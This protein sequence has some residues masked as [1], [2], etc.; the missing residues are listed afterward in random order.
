MA[1]FGW[2]AGIH[3]S[4]HISDKDSAAFSCLLGMPWVS[5]TGHYDPDPASVPEI[6]AQDC[7]TGFGEWL[8]P[9]ISHAIEWQLMTPDEL[10]VWH[11]IGKPRAIVPKLDATST[12]LLR[13]RARDRL[14]RH[15]QGHASAMGFVQGGPSGNAY[16]YPI[17][18]PG[19]SQLPAPLSDSL[20]GTT[21]VQV[22]P[23]SDIAGKL[24]AAVP[25]FHVDGAVLAPTGKVTLLAGPTNAPP[26]VEF[27][28]DG[29]TKSVG[30]LDYKFSG[31]VVECIKSDEHEKEAEPIAPAPVLLLSRAPDRQLYA[32]VSRRFWPLKLWL[33]STRVAK[34]E[35]TG[36]C[37]TLVRLLGCGEDERADN[38]A[39]GSVYEF[40]L[41]HAS[42]AAVFPIKVQWDR[43]VNAAKIA[44]A[45]EARLK[46]LTFPALVLTAF[47]EGLRQLGL[48]AEEEAARLLAKRSTASDAAITQQDLAAARLLQEGMVKPGRGA[49]PLWAAWLA[50][51]LPPV[52]QAGDAVVV[53][54]ALLSATKSAM[55]IP[56]KILDPVLDDD[57]LRVMNGQI[58][59]CE[60]FW[61]AIHAKEDLAAELDAQETIYLS[62][63][64]KRMDNQALIDLK[65]AFRD[66][67]QAIAAL[68]DPFM[69]QAEDA[70]LRLRYSPAVA[71]ESAIRGCILALR[72]GAPQ[73]DGSVAWRK[74]EWITTFNAK[75]AIDTGF[76][77]PMTDDEG[78]ALFLDTQGATRSDGLM[79]QVTAYAGTP[80]FT[81]PPAP[82]RDNEETLPELFERVSTARKVPPLAYSA[83][84]RAV[85]G[86][87]DNAGVILERDLW[88]EAP[89]DVEALPGLP[90]NAR[91]I[92]DVH[93]GNG[94]F[95]YL[96]KQPP[97]LPTF[98]PIEDH[99][100]AQDTL[101]FQA[102]QDDSSDFRV[103]V[104]YD[105]KGYVDS[106]PEQTLK[107]YAPTASPGFVQRWLSADLLVPDA[108]R[109]SAVK[110]WTLEEIERLRDSGS[111]VL[112]DKAGTNA[113][114]H[115]AV[116][117]VELHVRWHSS[118]HQAVETAETLVWTLHHLSGKDWQRKLLTQITLRRV[119]NTG[120]AS[121]SFTSVA[122]G[123]FLLTV[124][125]GTHAV[126]E[127]TTIVLGT[128]L[129]GAF[130]RF[131]REALVNADKRDRP[132]TEHDKDYKSL[133]A[134]RIHVE[135]LPDAPSST[136]APDTFKLNANEFVIAKPGTVALQQE[137]SLRLTNAR[138]DAQWIRGARLE[139]K[140]WQWSGYPVTFPRKDDLQSWLSLYS[141][142]ID[143]MP[144]VDNA[145][146]TTVVDAHGNWV[147]GALVMEPLKLA[148]PRPASH[149]GMVVTPIPR[150]EALLTAELKAT[151]KPSFVY[152]H[153]HGV[154]ARKRLTPPVWQEAIPLPHTSI[155][156]K[157]AKRQVNPGNLIVLSDPLY[158][159]SDTGA[160]GGIAERV[161]LDVVSTWMEG[162]EEIGPNPIF[163][164]SPWTSA[165]HG[166]A[167]KAEMEHQASLRLEAPFGLGYDRVVGG[168]PAQTGAVVRPVGAHGRWLLAKCR[169]R[170]LVI[171]DLILDSELGGQRGWLEPRRV[172][173][174]W[175]PEDFAVYTDKPLSTMK[176]GKYEVKLP[177][178]V[179]APGADE[180]LV[181]LVTWHRDRWGEAEITWRPLVHVYLRDAKQDAWAL[182]QHPAPYGQ[183][184]Y[185]L[186]QGGGAEVAYEL[187]HP[188]VVYHVDASDYTDSRWLSF[189]GSFEQEEV[190]P[191][192]RFNLK[193]TGDAFEL[194]SSA[195][196]NFE[197]AD[198]LCPTLLL[199]FNP[200]RDL[201][202]GRIAQDGG[203][204]VGVYA[205]TTIGSGPVKFDKGILKAEP[206]AAEPGLH[207]RAVVM[208]LQRRN[209][210]GA[211]EPLPSTW[212]DMVNAMFPREE[213]PADQPSNEARMRLVPEYIGP[214]NVT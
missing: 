58:D 150:F 84:Y 117:A 114:P 118:N 29:P 154:S 145:R 128:H 199:I 197:P 63:I 82:A 69:P 86:T 89:K 56:D 55:A 203:E 53:A 104:L 137:L 141:G 60:G 157:G 176:V 210:P 170:R 195:M 148:A 106:K 196:P 75:P 14:N 144:A 152:T 9:W 72:A 2:I 178:G 90:R 57:V 76:G 47:A 88:K 12:K 205:A 136:T 50:A 140:R 177:A 115:P 162:L 189:I 52:A 36:F 4:S 129:D 102:H 171:P 214:I 142:T 192:D 95:Q 78:V 133:R 168:R 6:P 35:A 166:A 87:V 62:T 112:Q 21:S 130:A 182:Q 92:G 25:V 121:R 173:D 161:E 107:L 83:Y 181:Y 70:P 138:R 123:G 45:F 119:A 158:D 22:A 54:G 100:V 74:G 64:A 120:P 127:A 48:G 188:A 186:E 20:L 194:S 185:P 49:H 31:C 37:R 201:M 80:L 180:C 110:G 44:A 42:Y 68:L 23:R 200:Q 8:A 32:E 160:F 151:I 24:V 208:K 143:A 41:D 174:G 108:H 13:A 19:L 51:V 211:K 111:T 27:E 66:G 67:V 126:L 98:G 81:A 38:V 139:A 172:E 159:T 167:G 17:M 59:Y 91:E 71:A 73:A 155:L 101:S 146:F 206:L 190:T 147:L 10:G 124:P 187:S 113:I 156:E 132:Y 15:V 164:K 209:S 30:G 163:H 61:G 169:M 109:W 33:D 79:E 77:A 134:V 1:A 28:Y 175:V 97:G 40:V 39:V 212:G 153:V 85:S 198:A 125:A 204:L 26:Q 202:R 183:A 65:A 5:T 191:A 3:Y 184:K 122:E 34:G 11:A 193:R 165:A 16:T 207:Q 94:D 105:G 116:V 103:A 18:S 7:E 135:S 213:R 131:K 46:E 149:M 179:A 93:W 99:G 96:S 43:V